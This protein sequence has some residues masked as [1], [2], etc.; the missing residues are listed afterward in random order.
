MTKQ[1]KGVAKVE[2]HPGMMKDLDTGV[3]QNTNLQDRERY[4][5]AKRTASN[6]VETQAELLK[7]KREVRELG[8][9][10]EELTELKGLLKQ[11]LDK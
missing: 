5:I 1:Q 9:V 7:L 6:N 11:L 8:S 2:G 4:R 10:K 3:I